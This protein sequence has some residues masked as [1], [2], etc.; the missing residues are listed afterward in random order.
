[1]GPM[2]D[3]AMREFGC[4]MAG[5]AGSWARRE[6]ETHGHW[7]HG[8]TGPMTLRGTRRIGIV[9]SGG[10]AKGAYQIG[11]LRALQDAGLADVRAVAGT[12]VGAM[13]G[14]LFCAR[15]LDEAEAIW[16]RARFRD[17]VALAT[18]QLS[19]FPL[20]VVAGLGSE[21]S[22]FKAWRLADSATHPVRWRRAVYP[23]A[24]LAMAAALVALSYVVHANGSVAVGLA[25]V[26][27]ASAMLSVTH[28]R[29][30][31]YFLLASPVSHGPMAATLHAVVTEDVCA[32]V[33]ERQIPVYATVSDFRPYTR[34]AIPW[35]GWAP[36]YVRLDRMSRREL[37][38]TLVSGSALPG[39]SSPQIRHR[40][41]S[42]D[43]AWTDNVPAAPL[44]FDE[45][46]NL[47]LVFV[48][49]L[50]RRARYRHRHNSL[51]SVA[52][53]LGERL[54]GLRADGAGDLV[55][56]AGQRWE[57]SGGRPRD[58]RRRRHGLC[59]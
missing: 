24:C 19:R 51:A 3:D 1:M 35:G 26:F 32:R 45:A 49:G 30:R 28:E 12:S 33:R 36:R 48:I 50:K 7:V 41:T 42:V 13:N 29:L 38:D 55:A 56:W 22:P 8:A 18:D 6:G 23:L 25:A 31:P 57:A 52:A 5:A 59:R 4:R 39:F 20:W 21:F 17:V 15:K 34:A 46:C 16:R 14:V 9:L 2:R 37:I 54:L 40:P 27:G 58:G 47:D 10:G 43:G 11:C 53:L 44:L